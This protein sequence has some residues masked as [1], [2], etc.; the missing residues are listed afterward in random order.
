MNVT[1][2]LRNIRTSICKEEKRF[3]FLFFFIFY[4]DHNET[5]LSWKST[6]P[7]D[8]FHVLTGGEKPRQ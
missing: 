5:V 3:T 1:K 6:C 4:K 2:K 7:F 8:L